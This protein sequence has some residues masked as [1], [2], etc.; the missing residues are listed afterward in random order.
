MRALVELMAATRGGLES[1]R[2]A[3][4]TNQGSCSSLLRRLS[5]GWWGGGK[6]E[7]YKHLLQS[8]D[9]Q[10]GSP[11]QPQHAQCT[12][13][14]QFF[15]CIC[16]GKVPLCCGTRLSTFCFFLTLSTNNHLAGCLFSSQFGRKNACGRSRKGPPCLIGLIHHPWDSLFAHPLNFDVYQI[17]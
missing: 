8:L 11:N 4:P 7:S 17:I 2:W 1:L 15:W 9:L 16:G 5:S 10:L 12:C 13:N 14:W 6:R 3:A